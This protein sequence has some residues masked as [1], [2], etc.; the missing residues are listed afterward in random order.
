MTSRLT[1]F[2]MV[3]VFC[4]PLLH[5]QE[6]QIED[7]KS[8]VDA[9]LPFLKRPENVKVVIENHRFSTTH[10]DVSNNTI[11]LLKFQTEGFQHEYAHAY[12]AANFTNPAGQLISEIQ[13][14]TRKSFSEEVRKFLHLK[15]AYRRDMHDT[16]LVRNLKISAASLAE[17]LSE[18]YRFSDL[19]E[20][21]ADA[22]AV[23]VN[24]N[25]DAIT[26][27]LFSDLN[28]TT[29]LQ[30]R[31]YD[32]LRSFSVSGKFVLESGF[33]PLELIM[34]VENAGND[35][36]TR[37]TGARAYIGQLFNFPA[38]SE[39]RRNVLK[40]VTHGVQDIL[41]DEELSRKWSKLSYEEANQIFISKIQRYFT[42]A[43]QFILPQAYQGQYQKAPD[44]IT[45]S[46][47][48]EVRPDCR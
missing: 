10:F 32:A 21:F 2:V 47:L 30:R 45:A 20:L 40:A 13:S 12:F 16:E 25:P 7:A 3:M 38:S 43:P 37:L 15:E 17:L 4:A 14:G 23:A 18:I 31:A 5:A 36:Y 11:Y 1:L 22:V 9:I 27:D 48:R 19:D 34:E 39:H 29:D 28:D 44:S 26:C 24:N 33:S 8:S 41:S 6:R 42:T 46:I 35:L